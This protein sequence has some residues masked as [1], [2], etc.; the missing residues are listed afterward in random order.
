MPLNTLLK[1]NLPHALR[2]KS[3]LRNLKLE[4][5]VIAHINMFLAF[6]ENIS[7]KNMLCRLKRF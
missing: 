4:D 5:I 1:N 3:G 6:W 2:Y 7:F